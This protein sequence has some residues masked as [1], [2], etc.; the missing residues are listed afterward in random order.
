LKTE[1]SVIS[2][3]W[4]S[5]DY[6]SLIQA[7]Y[8][9]NQAGLNTGPTLLN[10]FLIPQEPDH[11][12]GGREQ[13]RRARTVARRDLATSSLV[14]RSDRLVPRVPPCA[15]RHHSR[16]DS[17]LSTAP[18]PHRSI[19]QIERSHRIT[20]F[21]HEKRQIFLWQ[22]IIDAQ[23]AE[24]SRIQKLMSDSE[25]SLLEDDE[26][27]RALSKKYKQ[28][29]AQNEATV[30]RCRRKTEIAVQRRSE[31][32]ANLKRAMSNVS[33]T[34]SDI[35]KN[36]DDLDHYR[37][38]TA[39]LK[40]VTPQNQETAEYFD[41]PA[42][43][44]GCLDG[45]E[46][47]NLMLIQAVQYYKKKADDARAV[48]AATGPSE[49]E[50][51]K[52]DLKMEE[53][54]QIVGFPETL[55]EET[56]QEARDQDSEYERIKG[57]I[58]S[59]YGKCFVQTGDIGPLGMLRQL[60]NQLEAFYKRMDCISPAF[61]AAKAALQIKIRREQQRQLKQLKQEAEQKVKMEQALYRATRPIHK[62]TGRPLL[63][64]SLPFRAGN[65]DDKA[66]QAAL[67]EQARIEELLY[68]DPF[69]PKYGT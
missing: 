53:L 61:I 32:A 18:V 63:M 52:L 36:Q 34:K 57:E 55:N 15:L 60:E 28:A 65:D 19:D 17:S 16:G 29:Q 12:F 1:K 30:N 14:Q 24:I 50:T 8:Q 33:T 67:K 3:D 38:Y 54:A 56:L 43:L 7:E 20:E 44:V 68:A 31:L 62:R 51:K 59:A 41:V 22:M 2:M 45:I 64:R 47:G 48:I 69:K 9:K 25:R 13:Q 39:F 26:N 4:E 10:P 6:L 58:E 37:T 66:V 5:D 27:I 40:E 35:V 42:K 49:E 46:K 23:Q 11:L 21:L